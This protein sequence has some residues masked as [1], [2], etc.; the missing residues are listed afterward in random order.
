MV[1]E[2]YLNE[3][4]IKINKETRDTDVPPL[5]VS[6]EPLLKQPLTQNNLHTT[7]A[8]FGVTHSGPHTIHNRSLISS[9]RHLLEMQNL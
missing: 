2:L 1:C 7:E 5:E 3:T 9:S 6:L 8:H 4:I